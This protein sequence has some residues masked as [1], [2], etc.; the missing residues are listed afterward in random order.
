MLTSGS[1]SADGSVVAFSSW[2]G[3]LTDG[4]SNTGMELFVRDAKHGTLRRIVT[5]NGTVHAGFPALSADGRY[6]AYLHNWTNGFWIDLMA[7]I[8]RSVKDLP[9]KPTLGATT[10][11]GPLLSPNGRFVAYAE[12]GWAVFRSD[13]WSNPPARVPVSARPGSDTAWL[14]SWAAPMQ[15]SPDGKW[16]AFVSSAWLGT[17]LVPPA[18]NFKLYGHHLETRTTRLVASVDIVTNGIFSGNSRYLFFQHSPVYSNTIVQRHDL[19]SNVTNQTICENCWNPSPDAEGRL[20]AVQTFRWPDYRYPTRTY[21]TNDIFTVDVVTGQ[22]N[23]VSV[24]L[25]GTGG[26]NGNSYNPLMSY[27]GRYVVFTSRASDLV[28]NDNNNAADVFVRDLHSGTTML[29]SRNIEGTGS[30]NGFSSA[31]AMSADGRTVFFQSFANDLTPG[32]YNQARDIYAL[33]LG[34]PDSDDDGMDDD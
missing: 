32:D 30:G 10:F 12:P 9:G 33:K 29:V 19:L 1:V 31:T 4:D 15:F 21:A 6:M 16:L 11:I 13:M 14:G 7:G 34:G 18:G 28:S 26:G 25:S 24:N 2:D 23:L 8:T 5:T 27:D 3:E 20:V 22:S 17:N